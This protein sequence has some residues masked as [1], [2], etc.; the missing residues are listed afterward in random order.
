MGRPGRSI[1]PLDLSTT[2]QTTWL[3][4]LDRVRFSATDRACRIRRTGESTCF[5]PASAAWLVW[6][7][8]T[9]VNVNRECF[10]CATL[11]TSILRLFSDS[12]IDYAHHAAALFH[13]AIVRI[14]LLRHRT[15]T[16]TALILSPP[17]LL[18][19]TF[20]PC[21]T[22]RSSARLYTAH[23]LHIRIRIRGCARS[24]RYIQQLCASYVMTC[25]RR[26]AQLP[27]RD[28]QYCTNN[29]KASSQRAR[30]ACLDPCCA[31][32][33]AAQVRASGLAP[34]AQTVAATT[35]TTA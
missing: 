6:H 5:V 27:V 23:S 33:V 17:T 28:F 4:I 19:P 11:G 35:H 34:R 3:M 9:V 20:A 2:V 31:H 10:K 8:S 29:T 24:P 25:T 12:F 18:A 26:R 32:V 22:A 13:S 21:R 16:D 15:P 30:V 1:R 7:T 14:A